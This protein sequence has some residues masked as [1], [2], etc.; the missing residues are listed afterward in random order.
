MKDVLKTI[1]VTGILIIVSLLVVIIFSKVKYNVE[2]ILSRTDLELNDPTVVILKDRIFNNDLRKAK[3]IPSELSDE[4]LITFTLSKLDKNDYIEKSIKPVKISCQV[5]DE[6]FFT[7]GK[8]CNIII[9]NNSVFKDYN[10]KYFDIE[11]DMEY[12]NVEYEGYNCKNDGK[13]YYCLVKDYKKK[14]VSY[15][16]LKDAY[17]TKDEVVIRE[18]Y[19]KI[20]L[21][22]NQ[23]CLSYFS[24]DICNGNNNSNISYY[25]DDEIIKR[26]GVLYEHTFKRK[27]NSF[28]LEESIISSDT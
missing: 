12:P 14:Y 28:Y 9:I 13:R 11:R 8:T 23:R 5:T 7:S 17:E 18:Y 1:T 27:D 22:N 16:T 24:Q 6:I 26:D 15:S 20:E 10:K 21:T 3:L 25:I 19:L 2:K 4:E